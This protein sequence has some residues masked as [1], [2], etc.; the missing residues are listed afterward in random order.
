MPAAKRTVSQRILNVVL[1]FE[2]CLSGG[3]MGGVRIITPKPYAT[4][5]Y[6]YVAIDGH[7]AQF[8]KDGGDRSASIVDTDMGCCSCAGYGYRRQCRH[9]SALAALRARKIIG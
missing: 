7:E 1:P 2:P 8:I 6:Y 4:D 9:L 5:E 3:L